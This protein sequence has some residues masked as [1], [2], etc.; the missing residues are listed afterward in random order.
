MPAPER[1]LYRNGACTGTV[2]VPG[3][4]I[5]RVERDSEADPGKSRDC[6]EITASAL[7]YIMFH[8]KHYKRSTC[9]T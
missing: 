3:T 5:I 6:V 2:P 4:E 9:F 8:V 1:R 7:F